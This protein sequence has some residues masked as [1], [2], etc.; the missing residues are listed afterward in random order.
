MQ[1]VQDKQALAFEIKENQELITLLSSQLA[2]KGALCERIERQKGVLTSEIRKLKLE[3]EESNVGKIRFR[4]ENNAQADRIKD[5]TE[6]IDMC[7]GIALLN[8][9]IDETLCTAE[10]LESTLANHRASKRPRNE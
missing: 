9:M 3:L 6:K 5:L 10:T 8:Q 7:R 2:H 4:N 1:E